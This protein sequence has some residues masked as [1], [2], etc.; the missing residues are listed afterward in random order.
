MRGTAGDEGVTPN[1]EGG[2]G[3]GRQWA[4]GAVAGLS[5]E[6][7]EA[8]RM[9]E[10]NQVLMD[11][12]VRSKLEM[13]EIQSAPPTCPHCA[14]LPPASTRP[15]PAPPPTSPAPPPAF[16]GACSLR[17]CASR[18]GSPNYSCLYKCTPS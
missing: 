4:W 11:S 17:T 7:L 12:L 13:A 9:R 5:E 1:R 18:I 14:P 16:S 6:D 8:A 10:E 2:E 3:G 15:R